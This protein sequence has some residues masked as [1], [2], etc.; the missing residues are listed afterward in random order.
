MLLS[1]YT[2]NYHYKP[3]NQVND[4]TQGNYCL[5]PGINVGLKFYYFKNDTDISKETMHYCYYLFISTNYNAVIFAVTQ[6]FSPTTGIMFIVAT[7]L[8]MV[9]LVLLMLQ[10]KTIISYFLITFLIF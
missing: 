9:V 5:K 7:S 1:K 6:L 3:D 4:Q 10:N 8:T 2:G